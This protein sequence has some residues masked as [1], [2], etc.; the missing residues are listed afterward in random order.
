[1][2]DAHFN[3]RAPP[4][5]PASHSVRV[6]SVSCAAPSRMRWF[7]V[8]RAELDR[9][10]SASIARHTASGKR[11]GRP[12]GTLPRDPPEPHDCTQTHRARMPVSTSRHMPHGCARPALRCSIRRAHRRGCRRQGRHSLGLTPQPSHV[13]PACSPNFDMVARGVP[14]G[15]HRRKHLSLH[16]G[17]LSLS[18][19]RAHHDG[20]LLHIRDA[21]AAFASVVSR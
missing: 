8:K 15:Q 6:R 21:H 1:V 3:L 19:Q 13:I 20:H 17:K 16:P 2:H 9:T 11:S 5:H 14:V 7:R 10:T 12:P 18:C 4:A